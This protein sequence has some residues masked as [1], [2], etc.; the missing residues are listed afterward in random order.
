MGVGCFLILLPF[1]PAMLWAAILVY[2]LWPLYAR[3]SRYVRPSVAAFVITVV[4]AG[5]V[6]VPLVH[7][8]LIAAKAARDNRDWVQ[9]IVQNG[10]PPAPAFL[11]RVPLIGGILTAS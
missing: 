7:L 4:A 10:L 6:L 5:I 2:C 8:A 11:L 1:L 3:F 9:G